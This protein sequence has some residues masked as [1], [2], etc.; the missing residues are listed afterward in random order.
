MSTNYYTHKN[1][2]CI[3]VPQNW[4]S[5]EKGLEPQVQKQ[6]AR[7]QSH[8][9]FSI[10]RTV[11][12]KQKILILK[13]LLHFWNCH[14]S[15]IFIGIRGIWTLYGEMLSPNVLII[16]QWRDMYKG[17]F[18]RFLSKQGHNKYVIIII[19]LLYSLLLFF[20]SF[21]GFIH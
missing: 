6:E 18:S 9:I 3:N 17:L 14:E 2:Q 10:V 4:M 11:W 8:R 5:I 19:V 20:H 16:I 7:W 21:C 13:K 12:V 15:H 1:T